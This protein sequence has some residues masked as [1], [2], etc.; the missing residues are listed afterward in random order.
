MKIESLK[1]GSILSETSFFIVDKVEK[2]KIIVKDEN[3][4][5]INISKTYAERVLNGADYFEEEV[6]LPKTQL[7]DILINNPR[8]VMTVAFYK[9]NKEKTKKA[10]EAEKLAKIK[11]IQEASL[12]TAPKLLSDL[13][14]NPI[15][16][17]IPGELRVMKGRH[18][19]TIDD[20][21][22]VHFI[23]MEVEKTDGAHDPRM[24]QVD[25]RTIEYI[26]VF[27]KKYSLK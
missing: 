10:F 17:V 7:A 19:G 12:A 27:G 24:R 5:S 11:E 23:D 26:I 15:S 2:D 22:R 14:E 25:P 21:G 18:Y 8:V 20:L 4:N 16:K 9:Q 13:I 3:G 1:K 6:K